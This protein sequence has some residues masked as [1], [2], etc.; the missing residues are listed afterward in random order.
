[1][2]PH[3]E[4]QCGYIPLPSCRLTEKNGKVVAYSLS[5]ETDEQIDPFRLTVQ[6]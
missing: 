4:W 2:W 6:R 1:M 5:L 3:T